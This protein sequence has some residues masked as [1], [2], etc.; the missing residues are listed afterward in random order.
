MVARTLEEL[1][2]D[3]KDRIGRLERQVGLLSGLPERLSMTGA[4]ITDWNTAI[5]PGFYWG[6]SAA[7]APVAV[8][9]G[10]GS[11][12]TGVVTYHPG[13]TP[14]YLQEVREARTAPQ[15][16]SYRRYWNG[17]SWTA[18]TPSASFVLFHGTVANISTTNGVFFVWGATGGA[19]TEV[20]DAYAAHSPTTNPTR[21]TVATAGLYRA[22]ARMAWA[23]STVGLRSLVVSV[24]GV[25]VPGLAPQWDAV[26]NSGGQ[27]SI[28]GPISLAA[29]DYIDF[30]TRQTS[31]GT[32]V[33]SNGVATVEWLN[34]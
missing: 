24:N 20:L 7:N 2:T 15:S 18:W 3:Y 9:G 6:I 27:Q 19:Y 4:A 28:D 17:T 21:I 31:G 12:F 10:S 5:T 11:W 33:L 1:L 30:S 14:R 29:G 23:A 22:S 13:P 32:L 8:D 34:L 26:N 16:I 25:A